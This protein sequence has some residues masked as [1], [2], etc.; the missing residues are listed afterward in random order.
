MSQPV[1]VAEI[2][3]ELARAARSRDTGPDDA[4]TGAEIMAATGWGEKRLRA[5]LKTLKAAGSLECVRVTRENLVGQIVPVP[6]Y[7]L[8][9]TKPALRKVG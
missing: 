6:A 8:L 4:M 9:P 5:N 3:D 2:L 1:T 7:R